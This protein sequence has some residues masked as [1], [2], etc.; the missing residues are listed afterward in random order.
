MRCSSPYLVMSVALR[1]GIE[2]T[3]S[4]FVS[5]DL[6]SPVSGKDLREAADRPICALF[7]PPATSLAVTADLYLMGPPTTAS[8]CL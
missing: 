1:G 3:K 8:L 6:Y 5:E 7:G 2:T 4:P